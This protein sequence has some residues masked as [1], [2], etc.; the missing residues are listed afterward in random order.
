MYSTMDTQTLTECS[1]VF[2]ITWLS[3]S[4]CPATSAATNSVTSQQTQSLSL[5]HAYGSPTHHCLSVCLLARYVLV[6]VV[7]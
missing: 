4:M 3:M 1:L 5:F 2:G 6:L 7:T